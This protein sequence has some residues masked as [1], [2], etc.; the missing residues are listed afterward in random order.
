MSREFSHPIQVAASLL[1]AHIKI[2]F[3]QFLPE[4]ALMEGALD[5]ANASELF[6]RTGGPTVVQGCALH[7]SSQAK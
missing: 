3:R 5:L 1:Y 2:H 7:L 4:R 6:L